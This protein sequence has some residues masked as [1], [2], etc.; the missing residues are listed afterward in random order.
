MLLKKYMKS[1]VALAIVALMAFGLTACGSRDADDDRTGD[2]GTGTVNAD[3][4]TVTDTETASVDPPPEP[5]PGEPEPEPDPPIIRNLQGRVVT[6]LTHYDY[7]MTSFA[8]EPDPAN[9][10]HASH[11]LDQLYW[12]NLIRIRDTYNAYIDNLVPPFSNKPPKKRIYNYG[13]KV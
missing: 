7:T 3:P 9:P 10:F 1:L 13:N 2:G 4:S 8:D 5:T 11:F 6:L 12:Q